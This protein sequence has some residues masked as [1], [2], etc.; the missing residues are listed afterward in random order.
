MQSY[1]ISRTASVTREDLANGAGE[2]GL[3]A[4]LFTLRTATLT[5]CIQRMACLPAVTAEQNELAS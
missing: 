2:R 4:R 5:H 1:S 3:K